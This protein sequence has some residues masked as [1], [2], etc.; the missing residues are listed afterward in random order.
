MIKNKQKKHSNEW[1]ATHSETQS[2][3]RTVITGLTSVGAGERVTF[4]PGVKMFAVVVGS[5]E[6]SPEPK[7]KQQRGYFKQSQNN[8]SNKSQPTIH[9][10]R[11]TRHLLQ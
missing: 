2:T 9:N 10:F 4:A 6:G 5:I 8:R 1:S 11:F 3:F 7:K